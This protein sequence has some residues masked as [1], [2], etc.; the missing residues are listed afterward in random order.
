MPAKHVSHQASIDEVVVAAGGLPV[1]E[2][3][4][5]HI[6]IPEVLIIT[7]HPVIRKV[8]VVIRHSRMVSVS[9]AETNQE[10]QSRSGSKSLVTLIRGGV[11]IFGLLSQR[12]SDNLP[13][14][15]TLPASGLA[16]AL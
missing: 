2:Q 9:I 12:S 1:I 10:F 7:R 15:T 3:T 11:S 16:A 6:A 4:T 5:Y 14:C 13:E 8:I